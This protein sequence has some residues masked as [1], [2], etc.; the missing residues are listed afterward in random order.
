MYAEVLNELG[1][2]SEAATYVNFGFYPEFNEEVSL[3]LKL[4]Y[5]E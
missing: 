3:A 2:S 1:N 4:S 5:T